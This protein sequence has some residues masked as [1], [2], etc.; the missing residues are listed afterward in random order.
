MQLMLNGDAREI[1]DGAT[2]LNLLEAVELNPARVA[3]ERNR[4]IIPRSRYAE[5]ALAPGD[6][7]EIVQFV[8]GG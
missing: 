5:T 6:R 1:D 7:I 8:G 2:L 3:V 4:E